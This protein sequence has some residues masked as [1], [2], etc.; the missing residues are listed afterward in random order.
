MKEI[1]HILLILFFSLTI[2]SCAKKADSSSS[3]SGSSTSTDGTT[4]P[5][6]LSDVNA[7]LSGKSLFVTNESLSL[8][9]I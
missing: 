2:I 5:I 1:L 7:N 9:H 8:I 4:I 6:Q 3:S